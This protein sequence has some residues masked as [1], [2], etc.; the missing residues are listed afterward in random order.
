MIKRKWTSGAGNYVDGGSGQTRPMGLIFEEVLNEDAG[1][2]KF[3]NGVYYAWGKIGL[4]G[5]SS[6]VVN[7]N[8]HCSGDINAISI[9]NIQAMPLDASGTFSGSYEES[10]YVSILDDTGATDYGTYGESSTQSHHFFNLQG[11]KQSDEGEPVKHGIGKVMWFVI[12]KHSD[13]IT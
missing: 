12:G 13:T 1:Y 3:T 5:S 7:M 9:I 8:T 6:Y 10:S 4:M 11:W 2:V